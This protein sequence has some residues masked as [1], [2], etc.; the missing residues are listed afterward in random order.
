[1]P[2]DLATLSSWLKSE[3]INVDLE[4]KLLLREAAV[5]EPA[6]ALTASQ[7]YRGGMVAA[8]RGAAAA[9]AETAEAPGVA[10][11][12]AVIRRTT[13]SSTAVTKQPALLRQ[14]RTVI[15]QRR[16]VIFQR[17]A[18]HLRAGSSNLS[19]LSEN[20]THRCSL[21]VSV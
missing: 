9:T 13:I 5:M 15:F 2:V 3:E 14:R 10:V 21:L 11:G 8:G 16:T 19:N 4:S 17:R 6:T 1:M 18:G 20:R 7:N 12:R